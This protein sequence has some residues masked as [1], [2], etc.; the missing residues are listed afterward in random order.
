MN[1]Q[2]K[3]HILLKIYPEKPFW[4]EGKH[5]IVDVEFTVRTYLSLN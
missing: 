5:R 1:E 2:K 4:K 3:K